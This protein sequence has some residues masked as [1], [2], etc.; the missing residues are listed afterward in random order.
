[1]LVGGAQCLGCVLDEGDVIAVTHL[2]D[3]I[4]VGALAVEMDKHHRFG[5]PPDVGATLQRFGQ[6]VRVHVPR[7]AF[8]VHKDRARAQVDDGVDAANE[9]KRRNKDFIALADAGKLEGKVKCC[10]AG[11][12]GQCI[13][14]THRG[15]E[16]LFEP[17]DVGANRRDPIAV[18]GILHVLL[19]SA[20]HVRR[21]QVNP[22]EG[23]VVVNRFITTCTFVAY[24]WLIQ[25]YRLV[26]VYWFIVVDAVAVG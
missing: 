5:Q 8:T 9:G 24:D 13:S 20:R 1:M 14:R 15:A 2:K 26:L 4:D 21:R 22:L 16:L 7:T 18:E 11:T 17:I 6:N 12:Y 3:G 25:V 10:C 23:F 19:F